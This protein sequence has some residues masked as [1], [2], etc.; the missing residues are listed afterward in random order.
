M[1]A[2]FGSRMGLG[3]IGRALHHPNY[4]LFFGGQSISLL[5]TWMQRIAMSWLVYRLTNSV[6][7]LGVVGF[8]GQIPIF[9]LTPF[10]GVLAD[11]WNRHRIIVVTQTLSM[12]QALTLAFLILTGTIQVWHI[13]SLGIFLGMI[14]SFDI[15]TRQS[16]IADMVEN[17]D[18]LGNAIALN[19]SMVNVARL[20]G[21]SVAGVLIASVGEGVCFLL[22]GVSYVAVILS[23]LAM[24]IKPVKMRTIRTPIFRE[25]G[26]GFSYAF[27]STRIRSLLLLIALVSL[28]GMPYMVLM[29]VFA[30]DILQGNSH[31]LGFLMGASGFGALAGALFLAARVNVA[32]LEGWNAFAAAIFG[33]GLIAVSLS[34]SIVLSLFLM[35]MTGFGMI[36]QMASGNTVLQ[37]LVD[38]DK[39]GR[40]MSL[41]AMAVKGI[42][43]FGSLLAG[44]LASH[45]GAPR[46]L[47]MGG[48]SCVLGSLLFVRGS[49]KWP[50]QRLGASSRSSAHNPDGSQG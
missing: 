9:I 46:T 26:E 16:F 42:I 14:D 44:S 13:I 50:E 21:P 8:M 41:Y 27:R 11:R 17:R 30:K 43:P 28:T 36:V 12:L 35:L 25:L 7:L 22:N 19:S 6:F 10:A 31:T 18:D 15:P 49:R 29:P 23:L 2:D 37:T 48:A 5:G 40:I 32:G 39:R 33:I 47:M 45:I 3:Q 4:R 1:K 24:K 20:V 38:E 34:R